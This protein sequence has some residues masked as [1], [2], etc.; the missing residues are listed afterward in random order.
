MVN[1]AQNNYNFR[2][3]D[4]NYLIG[5]VENFEEFT[6]TS[7]QINN[8]HLYHQ[9]IAELYNRFPNEKMYQYRHWYFS[10][11]NKQGSYIDYLNFIRKNGG[12][13]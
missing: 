4:S 9:A 6:L 8:L 1:Q 7:H 10:E 11:E 5:F 12:I 13:N 3:W 2:E